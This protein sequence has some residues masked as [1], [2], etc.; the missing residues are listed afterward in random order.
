MDGIALGTP[1]RFRVASPCF[2]S[3]R[4]RRRLLS[5][6]PAPGVP[7]DRPRRPC[8]L[9]CTTAEEASET[10]EECDPPTS[11]GQKIANSVEIKEWQNGNVVD[12]AASRQ[13]IQI[14]RRPLTG[15]PKHYVGP[16]EFRL[17][18]E[19]NTPRNILEKII[20][21]KDMEVSQLKE[22]RPL[23]TLKKALEDAPPVRDFVGALKASVKNTGMPALIAEVKKAS[24]SRGVLR[25]NFDPVKIASAYE[26][27]GAT[28]IS[29][30]TDEKYFQGSFENLE[31]I[32]RAGVKCPLLCK[33]FIIDAWQIYYARSKGADAIL[34]IAAVLP[35]LDIKYLT[36]I[37]RLLGLATLV[38]VHNEREM[39]RVLS[40]E[41]IQLIGIN[42]RDLETFQVDISNTKRL[43]EGERGELI[44][45]R[46]II[47]LVFQV[48]GESGL[49]T[50]EDISYVQDAGVKAVLVGES[51][52][53]QDDPGKA[54]SGLFGKDI[55]K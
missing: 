34:L 52:I 32:R 12:N 11:G 27:F 23:T 22:R 31:A 14:R 45:Q 44:R 35:D 7:M 19:G 5:L 49:F 29:V 53:K 3:S 54:I 39:D 50:P 43:L 8:A 48:V 10:E 42:N 51:L 4:F 37:C 24:P 25:E 47:N 2:S 9:R 6:D 40:I 46:D 30:L 21:D 41:G 16:F 28:C 36:K 20:W 55:S 17:E 15:P 26:K 18:N 33:E 38:E 13:G 1:P